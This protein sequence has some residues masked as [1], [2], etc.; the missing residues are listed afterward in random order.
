MNAPP[1]AVVDL[2]AMEV[3]KFA[4]NVVNS[5]SNLVVRR[6][7]LLATGVHYNNH[8][9]A[10]DLHLHGEML[11]FSN[12]T[13]GHRYSTT[14]FRTRVY[15]LVHNHRH[16]LVLVRKGEIEYIECKDPKQLTADR[17]NGLIEKLATC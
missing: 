10:F 4:G 14:I 16:Y 11:E 8:L 12:P 7:E 6:K 9:E 13:T 1:I 15:P 17:L 2:L 3:L 5:T